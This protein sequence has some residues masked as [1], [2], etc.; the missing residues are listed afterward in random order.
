MR[1][2][3][4]L[5]I[6]GF[7]WVIKFVDEIKEHGNNKHSVT[8]GL[9]DASIRTIFLRKKMTPKKRVEIYEH[10]KLHAIEFEYGFELDHKHVYKISRALA[11]LYFDNL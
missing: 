4:K 10:E 3:R 5:K 2:P 11:Q 6:N 1:I 7:D 8:L 9:C